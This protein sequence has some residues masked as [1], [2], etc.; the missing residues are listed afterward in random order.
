VDVQAVAI[1]AGLSIGGLS[2]GGLSIRGLGIG[3][4]LALAPSWPARADGA[5]PPRLDLPVDCAHAGR[6][7]VIKYFDHDPGPGL[8]DYACGD[9]VG[10]EDNYP[11]TSIAIRDVPEMA[12]GVAVRAAAAGTVLRVRDGVADTGIYGPESREALRAIGCGNAVVLDHGGGWTTVYCHLRQGSVGV[13]PGRRVAA[14][15]AMALVGMSGLTELPHLHF[16]VRH[17]DR[18]VDPFTGPDRAAA[19]GPGEHP[20]WSGAALAALTPYRSVL[21]RLTGFDTA[22]TTVRAVREGRRAGDAVAEDAPELVFWAEAIGLHAAD[23]ARLRLTGPDGRALAEREVVF[24]RDRAESFLQVGAE[25]PGAAWPAGAY[26]GALT[27][28][29]GAESFT[30]EAVVRVGGG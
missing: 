25:R 22:P 28:T 4:A 9:R 6:C 29:R 5:P 8:R 21:V 18:P 16:Q 12:A 2:I 7:D 24:D 14:G 20:L 11:G 15:E 17:D 10:G 30:G 1:H 26:R 3:L 19:C 13:A 23:R 27:I